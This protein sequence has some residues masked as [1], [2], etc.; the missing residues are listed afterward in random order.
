MKIL[1][2]GS[3]F[4]GL[5]AAIRLQAQGH[6]VTLLEKRDK[7]GGR[8]YVYQQDGFTFD[9][10]PTIITS[11]YLIHELF[12]ICGKNTEDYLTLI[13]LNPFYN[14]R[15]PDGSVFHYNDDSN[16]LIEQIKAFNPE[17]VAGYQRFCQAANQVF[18]KGLPLMTQPFTH[19]TDILKVAPDM[20]QLQSYKSVAGFVNQYI[21]DERLR[22]VFSFHPLLIGG[23]PFQSTS[24]YA[25]IHKLEQEFGIW[26]VKGGT[27]AL[28]KGLVQLFQDIGGQ[29]LLNTEVTEILI[30]SNTRKA[31]GV[32]LKNGK[33]I[34]ADA[35]VSNADVAFTYLKLIPPQFRR[36]YTDQKL[37]KLRYSIS[38]FVIYF[39]TNRRYDQMAHHE[40]IMGPRY[41][42]L[43]NDIFN[44]KQL[45]DDFSLYLHR[46]TATD[47]SLAPPGCDCWY[48]L[49]PIPNLDAKIDWKSQAKIYR[50]QIIQYLEDH[51]L[52]NLSQHIITEHYIDP[53]HFRETLNS[54]KGS[55]F[56]L[57]P[58]LMQSAWF[59][60]HNVSEDIP[61]LY[62]VGAGTHPGAGIP[63][64][65]SSAKIV[66]DLI[67]S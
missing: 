40:I 57:E 11:P 50:N 39:G 19:F 67:S 47:S 56:S 7:A 53:L 21:K 45:A 62:F 37:Q 25:M 4:G 55:A 31:T 14:V 3:G 22:Q 13:K 65:M 52:P 51:Y 16:H 60:P 10:G 35:I 33:L 29:L 9:G 26:F 12:N 27:G 43:M 30:D 64:V 49:S 36:K 8:A 58:T 15:F 48:V 5:S 42:G 34:N 41:R 38:L 46:P 18:K 6:Q 54:Y 44:R 23:N 17:D 59:R 66:A 32:S 61:N 20:I 24:I 63:G 2:I 28:V 1:G